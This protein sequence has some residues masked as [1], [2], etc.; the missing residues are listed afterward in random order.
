M[1]DHLKIYLFLNEDDIKKKS[2]LDS[3]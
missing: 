3:S 2:V 1:K